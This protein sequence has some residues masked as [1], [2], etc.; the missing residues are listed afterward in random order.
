MLTR[1]EIL[2]LAGEGPP[3]MLGDIALA[4]G[5][6]AREAE[7]KGISLSGHAAHLIVHGLLHLAGYEHETSD[8]DAEAMESLEI[9]ILAKMGLSDPYGDHNQNGV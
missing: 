7:A 2:E 9:R 4:H 5:T 1:D 3:V 6:C 8:A